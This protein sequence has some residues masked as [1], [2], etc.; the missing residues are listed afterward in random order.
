[1]KYYK[2]L[3]L[4]AAKAATHTRKAQHPAGWVQKATAQL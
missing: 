4:L 1:M 2:E 3:M